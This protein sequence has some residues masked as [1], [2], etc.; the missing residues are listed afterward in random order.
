MTIRMHGLRTARGL[1]ALSALAL[2]LA[3]AAQADVRIT[4]TIAG[5][6]EGVGGSVH[7]TFNCTGAPTCVGTYSATLQNSGCSNTFTIGDSIQIT[8][9]N[10]SAHPAPISGQI[11]LKNAD[12]DDTGPRAD[13][14]CAIRP[15]SIGDITFTYTGQWDGS[16]GTFTIAE[17]PT[18]TGT[19]KA[20]VVP[21]PPFEMKVRANIDPVSATAVA[22]IQFRPQDL[23][24]TQRIFTFALAPRPRASRGRQAPTR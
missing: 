15:G 4:G 16:R 7:G 18:L 19:Y 22:D 1:L 2:P 3:A 14:T 8:G 6:T 9:I 12:F 20:D 10:A 24:T 5:A 13:G 21:P 17:I 11:L 23:G